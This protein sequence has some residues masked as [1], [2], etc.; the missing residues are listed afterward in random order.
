ML[1]AAF[2]PAESGRV[3]G[4]ISILEALVVLAVPPMGAQLWAAT[5]DA[6]RVPL[7]YVTLGGIQALAV[8]ASC[9][10]RW[11]PEVSV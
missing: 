7:S 8:A 10:L 11:L 4:T 5:V 3:L 1:S 9:L 2:A 6:G